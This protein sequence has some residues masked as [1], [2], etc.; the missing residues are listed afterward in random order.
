MYRDLF[1]LAGIAI[2]GWL[3]LILAPTWKPTRRLAESAIMPAYLAA[4][5]AV[6]LVAFIR[7]SGA[8][9]MASFGTADGVVGLLA[10]EPIA[11]IAWIHILAFDQV[12]G[13]LIYR[14]N[15]RHRFVAMPIQSVILVLTLMVGPIGFALYWLLRVPRTAGAPVAW[16]V[17]DP[18][19]ESRAE[20]V[21][22]ADVAAQS[23]TR[24]LRAGVDVL[25]AL[26]RRE[27]LLVKTATLGLLLG[28]ANVVVAAVNGSWIVG[29][30]GRIAEAMKFDVAVGIYLLTLAA[31]A[32]LAG[33]PARVHRRWA[34][35][36]VGCSLYAFLME[37]GQAWRGLDPR[38]SAI[39]GP[40]DRM[41]GGV[42]FLSALVL[43][44]LFLEMVAAFFRDESLPDHPR[45]RVALRYGAVA[46]MA[47]FGVGIV[48]S[49][50]NGRAVLGGGNLMP[51]HAAGFHGLQAIP[52]IALLLGRAAVPAGLSVVHAA[53]AGWLLLCAGLL[54]QAM[55]GLPPAQPSPALAVSVLGALM[56]ATAAAYAWRFGGAPA[57][58]VRP[59]A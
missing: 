25:V 10:Q 44:G 41:L 7:E 36:I 43:M 47:S 30:E 15:M 31:I 9:F 11:L 4:L 12:A 34:A 27:P 26:W 33:M 55:L 46:A 22:W 16:G 1:D 56:W 6:G 29:A 8:G 2:L 58:A 24:S 32:P 19:P 42:F 13:L 45:L 17:R 5:Y 18:M 38:F 49:F 28:G 21:R 20:P 35:W 53:G 37:N 40:A 50:V 59:T 57:A 14:D 52:I 23:T 48:M 54:A 3:P 39:A 51:L